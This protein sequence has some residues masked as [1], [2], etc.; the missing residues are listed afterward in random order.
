[1]YKDQSE[2][3]SQDQNVPGVTIKKTQLGTISFTKPSRYDLKGI[4]KLEKYMH[5]VES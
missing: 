1:M 2:I 4:K 5:S 3:V